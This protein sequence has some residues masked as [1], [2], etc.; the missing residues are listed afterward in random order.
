MN[1]IKLGKER[2]CHL[3]KQ[4]M[5]SFSVNIRISQTSK[6]M[7]T[8]VGLTNPVVNLKRMH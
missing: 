5:H 2:L 8:V 4:L 6:L 1:Y 7:F 3:T